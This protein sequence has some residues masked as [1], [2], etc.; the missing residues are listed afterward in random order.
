[1]STSKFQPRKF[2]NFISYA[3][4]FLLCALVT[5]SVTFSH[6]APA[7]AIDAP[8]LLP[9]EQTNVIDLGK[10]LSG[11]EKIKLDRDL[12]SFEKKTGWKLRI[13]T[14][15]D[16]TPGRAVKKYWGLNE[17]SVLLV[18][19]SRDRNILNFNVGDDVYS[20]LPRGFWIELQSRYG[21]QFFV[22]DRG[23]D[24]AILS[25]VDA[26]VTC[27]EQDGCAVVPG[28]PQ[29]QWVLTLITSLVGGIIFGFAGHPR[30][31]GEFFAW[32]WAL[33]LAPLW[34]M[35]FLVFGIGPVVMRTG[36]ILPIIRNVAGFTGG[37]IIAYLIPSP[38]RSTSIPEAR[39]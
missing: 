37:A 15:V 32:R 24:R 4:N 20:L 3:I 6:A 39:P 2:K 9:Q 10:F 18:A 5:L 25:S 1:M 16:A 23:Q 21:N 38:K 31:E 14:Q 28:L 35:L 8:E 13:L 12:T 27:L 7:L 17:R 19:D 22:R 30:R 36:D 11:P 26:I 34:G 29:E 33:V